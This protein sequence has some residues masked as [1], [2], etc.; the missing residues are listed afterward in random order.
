[1]NQLKELVK[2]FRPSRPVFK[3]SLIKDGNDRGCRVQANDRNPIHKFDPM[4]MEIKD[5]P[6]L[7]LACVKHSEYFSLREQNFIY[8]SDA[9]VDAMVNE[10]RNSIRAFIKL[11][12]PVNN[13]H[14]SKV[15]RWSSNMPNNPDF[16]STL[17]M[18]Y[19]YIRTFSNIKMQSSDIKHIKNTMALI[20]A[21]SVKFS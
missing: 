8:S 17:I 18:V 6:L 10:I 2:G 21:L 20:E 4:S 12:A 16:N 13:P 9:H 1:M 14:R 19:K 5:N 3:L 11:Y 15:Y 7:E